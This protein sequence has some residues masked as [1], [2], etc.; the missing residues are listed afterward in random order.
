MTTYTQ[1]F[2]ESCRAAALKDDGI[3]GPDEE[4]ILDKIRKATSKYR[5]ELS[6]IQKMN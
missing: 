3:I 2:E 4:I 5:K 6:K 1:T